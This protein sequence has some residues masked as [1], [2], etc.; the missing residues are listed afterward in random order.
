MELLENIYEKIKQSNKKTENF[1]SS[2]LI[3]LHHIPISTSFQHIPAEFR[4]WIQDSHNLAF[5]HFF[6]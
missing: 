5:F 3:S 4:D 6:Q 1:I 2:H